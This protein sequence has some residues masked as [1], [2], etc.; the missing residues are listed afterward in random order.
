MRHRAETPAATRPV[1]A[2][3]VGFKG[4][5]CAGSYRPGICVP[6]WWLTGKAASICPLG[7]VLPKRAGSVRTREGRLSV[8][9][10]TCARVEARHPFGAR[11]AALATPHRTAPHPVVSE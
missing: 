5:I 4:S 1:P 11:R 9:A 3:D 8:R 10:S 2:L 6:G 7:R